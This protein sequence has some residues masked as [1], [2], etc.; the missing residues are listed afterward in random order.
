MLLMLESITQKRFLDE[1]QIVSH[2]ILT[3]S[4]CSWWLS[5]QELIY[6]HPIYTFERLPTDLQTKKIELWSWLHGIVVRC[7]HI[8]MLH[9][10]IYIFWESKQQ[11][12]M[13]TTLVQSSLQGQVEHNRW[14]SRQPW[15]WPCLA[16][17]WHRSLQRGAWTRSFWLEFK[18]QRWWENHRIASLDS[19]LKATSGNRSVERLVRQSHHHLLMCCMYWRFPFKSTSDT[20]KTGSKL[21]KETVGESGSHLLMMKYIINDLIISPD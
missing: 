16:L 20:C 12:T 6:S 10:L 9:Y 8:K 13:K 18:C 15:R 19:D 11:R 7:V 4:C 1:Q 5:I 2:T 3:C 21:S 17:A 14:C